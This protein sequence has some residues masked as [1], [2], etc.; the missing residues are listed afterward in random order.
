MRRRRFFS[1][2]GGAVGGLGLAGA[3]RADFSPIPRRPAEGV[4]ELCGGAADLKARLQDRPVDEAFWRLVKTQFLFPEGY[5]YLNTGGLGACPH[6]VRETVRTRSDQEDARPSAGHDLD[7]W[8][9]CKAG[10]APLLGPGCRPED[11]ALVSTATEG[12]N[13]VLNGLPLE[14]G[15]EVITTTHEH[16]ALNIP[17]LNLMATRG[18]RVRTFE[19]DL[20]RAAGNTERIERLL[21]RRTRLIFLSHVTCTT[22]QVLPIAEIGA[23][24]RSRGV[25]FALDGAQALAQVSFDVVAAGVDAYAVSCHKWVL[26]PRRTGLLYVREGM[27]ETI[28]PTVVGAYSDDGYDLPAGRLA[29]QASAQRYEFGTQNEALFY[30]LEEAV[31]F[32]DAI[33]LERVQARAREQAEAFHTGLREIAGAEVLSPAERNAR[34]AMITFRLRDLPY[35]EVATRLGRAGFRVRPVGEAGLDAIRISWYLYNGPDEVARVLA[36]IRSLAA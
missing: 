5:T 23:L 36:A 9:R 27:R 20:V 15:D 21:G 18:I 34:S 2:V 4:A 3:A 12:I 10:L 17:L 13:I 35:G 14:R 30:G 24:A 33:G 19:P 1:L 8:N 6:A 31:A 7:D 22:G 11:L 29:F 32:L 26:G 16:P 28:R 25:W